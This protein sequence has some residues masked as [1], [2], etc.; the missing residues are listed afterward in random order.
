MS[1]DIEMIKM[2]VKQELE[3]FREA[4]KLQKLRNKELEDELTYQMVEIKNLE[5]RMI[6]LTNKVNKLYEGVAE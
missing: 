1:V 4:Y 2:V 5:K 3:P 6:D